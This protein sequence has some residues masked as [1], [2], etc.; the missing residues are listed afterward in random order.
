[1]HF[2]AFMEFGNRA[3]VTESQAFKEG[4]R[5]VDS[6]EAMG[7]D[8][9]WLAELHFNPAR[10]VLSSPIVVA[11]AIAART[12]RL[13]VG[14]AVYVLPLSNPLRIAEE[15]ATVDHI[16][17]G[18]FEFGIGRSGFARSYDVF[19]IDYSESQARF[20]ES[21]EIILQAWQGKE[22]S[23]K[24][25]FYNVDKATIS[26]VPYQ[27]PHP[28]LRIAANSTETFIR[29]GKAGHPIFV[30]LRGMDIPELKENVKIYRETWEEA[31][32]AG[33]G[34]VSLRIPVYA[35]ETKEQALDEPFESISGYFGR[36][37]GLYRESA[38][39]AG[40]DST[41]LRQGRAEQLAALSYDEMLE[42][43]IAFGTAE[44]LIDRFAQLKEELGLD[45][46]LAELNAGGLIPEER[47][48]RSLRIITEKVMPAF[49]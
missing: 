37:G 43:K 27:Q 18:R 29:L 5:M 23:Y 3:G 39:K 47:V 26:P 32:H 44:G 30:G 46:V 8:G 1:M 16:S 45:G 20:A 9:V 21:M 12:K 35:G 7:L 49:K 11:S 48:L 40:I 19:S 2:G 22:F 33:H 13:R 25:E 4:F 31:G 15:V 6:A 42:T 36:M 38:G 41:E 24:G 28:P 10:S 34:D 14:M 17:E